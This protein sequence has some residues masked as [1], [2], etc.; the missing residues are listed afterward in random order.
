MKDDIP[1]VCSAGSGATQ[2]SD[3]Q[4]LIPEADLALRPIDVAALESFLVASAHYLFACRQLRDSSVNGAAGSDPRESSVAAVYAESYRAIV[5]RE[6]AELL[7]GRLQEIRIRTQEVSGR[8]DV[9]AGN[10]SRSTPA[11]FAFSA[12]HAN[13]DKPRAGAQRQA[14]RSPHP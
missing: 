8:S 4:V 13:R 12:S 3:A 10:Q 6:I 1:V 11:P 9:A 5:D 7:M 14:L 2:V